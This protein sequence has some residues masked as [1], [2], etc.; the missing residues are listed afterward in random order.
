MASTADARAAARPRALVVDAEPA[1]LGLLSEWL[2]EHGCTV[3]AENSDAH[4]ASGAFDFIVLDVPF[5]RSEGLEHVRRVALRYPGIPIV[6][7][8][9][10]FFA[11]I[12][13]SGAVAHSLGAAC[14]LPKPL[15]REALIAAVR[16]LPIAPE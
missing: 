5:A 12:D 3:V 15:A 16:R 8:S 13:T 10:S 4:S 11:G 1:L 6:A 9:A 7:L 14:V 2:E